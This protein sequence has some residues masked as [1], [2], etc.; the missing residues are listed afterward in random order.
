MDR[1]LQS[2]TGREPA[3]TTRG[4]GGPYGR[5]G[6]TGSNKQTQS[7]SQIVIPA[8]LASTRLPRKLLLAETGKPLIQHTYEAAQRAQRPDGVCVA[9]DCEEIATVVLGFGGQVILTSPDCASGTDRIAE[10]ARQIS[11][12][13]IFVNVQGDEPELSGDAIDLV[14]DLL[15]QHPMANMATLA[16]P[17]RSRE[18]LNDPACVKV[19]M[20]EA[21]AGGVAKQRGSLAY[22]ALYFSRAAIPHARE[23]RDE[24][25]TMEPP[26]FFQHLGLYA[27][28]REFLLSL[29][30]LPRTPLERLENLEQ[31]RVLENGEEILVGVIDEPTIGIDTPA[32]YAAFVQRFRDR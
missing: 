10:V 23:W 12:V 5:F 11:D 9:A 15:E 6:S 13:D 28:R 21:E 17:I 20:A 8:R 29:S 2:Q 26:Q 7:T 24:L 30:Q 1:S 31:L 3:A 27:Y 16:T 19:V 4:A 14:V 18:K 25:L 32:D 22:R